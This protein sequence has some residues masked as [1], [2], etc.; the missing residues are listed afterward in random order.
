MTNPTTRNIVPIKR[1]PSEVHT[2]ATAA[3]DEEVQKEIAEESTGTKALAELVNAS[4][5]NE[6]E[7]V[8]NSTSDDEE[9]SDSSAATE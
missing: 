9:Q 4:S 7:T 1:V 6:D 5:E 8:C 2:K 3:L